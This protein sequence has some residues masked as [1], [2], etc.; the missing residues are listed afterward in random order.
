MEWMDN[1][2]NVIIGTAGHID[3]GKTTLIRALTGRQTDRLKEEKERGISIELGFTY[4]DLPSGK[5]AGIIDVPGHEKFIRNMLAGATG[6]D[7]VML[8]VAADEGVMPQTKE[9]LHILNLLGIKKGLVVITKASLVDD[10]WLKLI[11]EDIKEN[12][13]DTFL[14]DSEM[15]LVDSIKKQG[16]DKLVD[17]LDK[18]TES[19]DEKNE[20]ETPRLPV[21]RVFTI[22]G[23]GTVVT[24][25][26]IAGKLSI[27]D[28]I[29]AFPGDVIGRIRNIQVHGKDSENVFGGQRVAINI[30]GIKKSDIKRGDIISK[31]N[32]MKPTMMIDV[33]LRLL[34]DSKRIIENRTRV[35]LYIG[36]SEI[37]CRVILLDKEKITPGEECYAQLRLEESTVA[38][39]KD[40]FIIR[41][42]SPMTTI[43]GGEVI[44]ANPPK[45][46]RFSEE[47]IDELKLKEKGDTKE[48][49]EKIILDKS[50]KAP[51]IKDISLLTVISE[52]KVKEEIEKLSQEGRIYDFELLKDIHTMHVSY[53]NE[54]SSKIE[55][56]LAEFHRNNTL[57]PGMLKEEIRSKYFKDIKPKLGDVII[58]KMSE[59]GNVKI[60][61][62]NIALKDF[63]VELTDVQKSIEKDIEKI[64]I[65]GKLDVPKKDEIISKLNYNKKDLDDVYKLML[66]SGI[67]IKIKEDII[68][69]K[70][71]INECKD[72]LIEYLK[73][74]GSIKAGEFRDLLKTN[75][76]LSIMILEYFD[77]NK[78]TKRLD[79]KR[80]I[81]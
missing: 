7:V 15:I 4:F 59:V 63:E 61:N 5:R 6:I 56:D 73:E 28:E 2:K 47:T 24:G 30:S 79:D 58:N 36:S 35:R 49:V 66:D 29:R 8:V 13:K 14:E 46:K 68:L 41:F 77:E 54:V 9:H 39:P 34:K 48:V 74:Q 51:S 16:I 60:I 23:F 57:K 69:H 12:I 55:K 11:K 26:L 71:T 62:E 44:D 81:F 37:L 22:S 31:P 52:E 76:K 42:Y 3:H 70:D 21:D 18:L 20:L 45:R 10:D 1:M 32:S 67:L 27:G 40:K 64:Y 19:I 38:K 53:F 43:G 50:R 78:I 17:T 80:V 75:R 65:D 33:K 72:T 25:T